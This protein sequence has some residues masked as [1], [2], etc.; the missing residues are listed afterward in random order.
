MARTLLLLT[1]AAN[2][3]AQDFERDVRPI[4]A[5]QC[6]GCHNDKTRSSG[7][8]LASKAALVEGGNRGPGLEWIVKAV[9][10]DGTLK[11]P[12]AGKLS[13]SEI[14]RLEQWVQSG[15]PWPDPVTAKSTEEQRRNHWAFQ[16]PTRPT[17]PTTRDAKWARTPVDQFILARLEREQLKP[18]P[19]ADRLT[20]PRRVHLDLTGILP[21]MSEADSFLKDASADADE[22][23]VDHLPASPQYGKYR[24]I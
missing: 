17:P 22:M 18:S 12:P 6:Q 24:V 1:I 11:M 15:A 23:A 8:S 3:S 2:L 7:L 19:E 4:F 21:T 16:V 5:R 10:Q 20:L 9:R 14:A 13:A